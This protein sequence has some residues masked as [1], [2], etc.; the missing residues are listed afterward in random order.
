MITKIDRELWEEIIHDRNVRL[1]VTSRRFAYFAL[2]YYSHYFTYALAPYHWE[3]FDDIDGLL[4]GELDEVCWVGHREC[5][6]T[7][8]AKMAVGAIIA[9]KCKNYLNYDSYAKENSVAALTDVISELRTNER[10]IA[11]Y[12][13]LF[14]DKQARAQ[15]AKKDEDIE[16]T[17]RSNF[18]T[19]NKIK[20]EAFSTQESTRGRL[21]KKHRPDFYVLDD[22]ENDKTKLMPSVTEKIIG[23]VDELRAGL[24]INSGVLYLGNLVT[25]DGVVASIMDRL[26]D[27]PRKRV[28]FYPVMDQKGVIAWPAKFCHTREEAR[29]FNAGRPKSEHKRSIEQ[30]REDLGESVF[31]KDFMLNPGASGDYF[32]DRTLVRRAMDKA[33][34]AD[35]N[36]A[37]FKTWGIYNPADRYSLGADVAEGNGND[38]SASCVINH[39]ATPARVVSTY[40]NNNIDTTQFS[41]ELKNQGYHFGEC[42]QVIEINQPGYAIIANMVNEHQYYSLYTREVKNKTTGKQVK[43]Y[44]WKANGGNVYDVSSQFKTAFE[45]G[46]LEILCIDLLTDMYHYTK[47]NVRNPDGRGTTKHFD[48]LRSAML[49]WEGRKHATVSAKDKKEMYKAPKRDP[50]VV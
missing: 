38:H 17:S 12:G 30:L 25:E 40:K 43:E 21:Y 24:G 4:S 3:M 47:E 28:R 10:F 16:V 6:K 36:V 15:M 11:D 49:A 20:A 27:K 2:Y 23:H 19:T 33:I 29:I 37:G 26:K 44:G 39:S 9:N 35:K 1:Y 46:E 34:M 7:S 41:V 50:Y 18:V 48:L 5:A 14:Y 31:Q 8:I 32:F 13:R 45:S 42:F 22:I